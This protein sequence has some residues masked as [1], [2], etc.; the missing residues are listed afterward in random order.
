MAKA[1]TVL[2]SWAKAAPPRHPQPGTVLQ[3]DRFHK[4]RLLKEFVVATDDIELAEL[5]PARAKR[6]RQHGM[7]A[8]LA[9]E[10]FHG[11]PQS[12]T[13]WLGQGGT[14]SLEP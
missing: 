14:A 8:T 13:I 1:V 7:R 12:G 9:A 3:E 4:P 5:E 2:E 6:I 10:I 11:A